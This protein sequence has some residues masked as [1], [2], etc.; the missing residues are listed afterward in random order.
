[1]QCAIA[2]RVDESYER[3]IMKA[4]WKKLDRMLSAMA[5]AE[6][7]DLDRVKEMLEQDNEMS[8]SGD[9]HLVSFP[10]STPE[11]PSAKQHLAVVR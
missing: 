5:F 10:A 11:Q 6:A 9:A 1:M 2:F 7:G 4:L 3:K 8:K